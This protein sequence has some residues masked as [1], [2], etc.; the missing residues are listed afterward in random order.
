MLET[1][2]KGFPTENVREFDG[3]DEVVTETLFE[4]RDVFGASVIVAVTWLEV[5]ARPL[6]PIPVG[7]LTLMDVAPSRFDPVMVMPFE[8]PGDG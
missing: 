3:P 1:A 2:G 5:D 7:G 4:P 6:I 8:S